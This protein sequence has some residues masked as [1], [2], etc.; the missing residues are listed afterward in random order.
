MMKK[1]KLADF[2]VNVSKLYQQAYSFV[3][4]KNIKVSSFGWADND[5]SLAPGI[6]NSFYELSQASFTNSDVVAQLTKLDTD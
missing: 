1:T 2:K 6:N 4:S 5:D 3:T